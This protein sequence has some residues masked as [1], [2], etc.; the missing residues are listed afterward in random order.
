MAHPY[1]IAVQLYSVRDEL[2]RDVDATIGRLADIGFEYVEPFNIVQWRD[3]FAAAFAAHGVTAPTAHARLLGHDQDEIFA[4][5]QALGVERVID[6]FIGVERWVDQEEILRAAD[7]LAAAGQKAAEYGLSLGYH[8]HAWETESRVAGRHG[9]E[10]FADRLPRSITLELDVYWAIVGGANATDLLGALG[11]RVTA[12]HL[13][14][15]PQ[16]GGKLDG[17]TIRQLPVGH[18]TIAWDQVL[19]AAPHAR[20]LVVEFDEYDGDIFEGV[21]LGLTGARRLVAAHQGGGQG[22]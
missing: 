5:A 1:T 21:S 9:L 11:E 10:V 7:E 4:A 12:L 17:D 18:G 20:H 8:N 22:E 15:G 14:D 6:P 3:D 19:A 13:K 2:A 16:T